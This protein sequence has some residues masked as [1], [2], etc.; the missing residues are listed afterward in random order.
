[1]QIVNAR[2]VKNLSMSDKF[3]GIGFRDCETESCLRV[4]GAPSKD[5]DHKK[6]GEFR[7][8]LAIQQLQLSLDFA[9]LASRDCHYLKTIVDLVLALSLTDC[10]ARAKSSMSKV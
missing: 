3:W 8:F 5:P 4:Q 1:V 10:R 2:D 9:L 7:I 6:N